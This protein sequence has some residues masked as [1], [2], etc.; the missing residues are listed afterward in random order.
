MTKL[1]SALAYWEE[2][3]GWR[4]SARRYAS[5]KS[6]IAR[7]ARG[8]R[9][10]ADAAAAMD[11]N[12]AGHAQAQTPRGTNASRDRDR[13]RTNAGSGGELYQA[14]AQGARRRC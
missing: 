7:G 8:E 10:A 11:T 13:T 5:A 4:G 2:G 12:R 1:M 9:E 3:R 14:D 6:A